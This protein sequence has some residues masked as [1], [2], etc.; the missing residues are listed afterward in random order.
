MSQKVSQKTDVYYWK[1][2]TFLSQLYFFG[3][4][5]YVQCKT[6]VAN[7]PTIIGSMGG[8]AN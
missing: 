3:L 8:K 1:I 5:N 4:F 6:K 7:K 2:H